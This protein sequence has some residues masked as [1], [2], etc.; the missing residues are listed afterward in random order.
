LLEGRET[1]C[2]GEDLKEA[3][4]HLGRSG[5]T[6]SGMDAAIT[7]DAAAVSAIAAPINETKLRLV[8]IITPQRK[9][10]CCCCIPQETSCF[11]SVAAVL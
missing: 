4:F 3:V 7:G 9:A 1:C 6:I 11:S 8:R 10:S 2:A 5:S